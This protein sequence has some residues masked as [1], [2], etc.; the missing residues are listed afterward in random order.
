MN[1]QL[2]FPLLKSGD[3]ILT[4]LYQSLSVAKNSFLKVVL[5]GSSLPL[6]NDRYHFPLT[7]SFLTV[8]VQSNSI[9]HIILLQAVYSEVCD[10]LEVCKAYW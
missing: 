7:F 3:E 4:S 9:K 6:G 1:T 2:M 5:I 10:S 8:K